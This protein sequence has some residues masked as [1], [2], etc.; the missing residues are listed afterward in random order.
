[1]KT[2]QIISGIV[3]VLVIIFSATGCE[4]DNKTLL[5]D[6]IWNFKTLTSD[7]EDENTQNW[8]LLAK[9]LMTEATIEFQEDGT[10]ILNS[11]LMEEPTTGTWS[12]IG[13]DQLVMNPE[14]GVIS[15]QNIQVLTRND[16]KY[17]ET[18]PDLSQNPATTTTSWTR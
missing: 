5:T 1:M 12:L 13:D 4:Q 2:K 8:I 14:G 6:G 7:S 3:M 10:Y 16:L 18:V 17:I 9:A 15:T 11:P